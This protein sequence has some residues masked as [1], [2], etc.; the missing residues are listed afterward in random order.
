[1]VLDFDLGLFSAKHFVH[2][3]T[4]FVV[5]IS[6]YFLHSKYV[7]C[8]NFLLYSQSPHKAMIFP[9]FYDYSIYHS[10]ASVN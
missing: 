10:I 1:M 4:G 6:S 3:S 2:F 8:L 7:V 5:R 9:S